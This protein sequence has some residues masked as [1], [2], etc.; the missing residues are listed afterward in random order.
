MAYAER[1]KRTKKLTGRWVADAQ[2]RRP[3]GLT[4]RIHKAFDTKGQAEGAEAYFRATGE[5]PGTPLTGR[6]DSFASVA[7]RFRSRNPDW[8]KTH[9]GTTNAQRLEYAVKRLGH[10]DI[11]TI[12]GEVLDR[13]VS[14][15]QTHRSAGKPLAN[16]TINRYLDAVSLVLRFAL[17]RELIQ[18]MPHVPRLK[19]KGKTRDIVSLDME[20]RI[21]A[22][23]DADAALL[24]R[25]LIETGLRLGELYK[26]K[27]EQIETD[28]IQLKAEQTKTN[29]ARWVPIDAVYARRL[30]DVMASGGLV[31][32]AHLYKQFKKA[33]AA[34]G[35]DG[36]LTL[37]CLR[38]TTITRLRESGAD[39]LDIGVIVGHS[40]KDVTSGYY[41]PSKEHLS[42]VVK[43]VHRRSGEITETGNIIEYNR[44]VSG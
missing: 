13:F 44:R 9:D 17:E 39:G 31:S 20:D 12:R 33:A 23:L 6:S 32:K 35:D 1:N 22:A 2:F 8:L 38:H 24:V 18:G 43:K 34:S 15:L 36:G 26:L 37:H 10:L 14:G 42:E 16:R 4:V 3:D 19:N 40:R 30:R 41:H 5:L 27:P 25:V 29:A 11:K 28:G 21:C 7:E